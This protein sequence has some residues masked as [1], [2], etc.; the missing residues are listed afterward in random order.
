MTIAT[1]TPV[2]RDAFN[3]ELKVGDTVAV[4]RDGFDLVA[5]EILSFHGTKPKKALVIRCDGEIRPN[6]TNI[7][8]ITGFSRWGR[9]VRRSLHK[10]V[11]LRTADGRE[12]PAYTP[13]TDY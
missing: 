4:M 10:L 2:Y 11:L 8:P 13:T 12:I 1:P 7:S 9:E 6:D 5:M 3:R